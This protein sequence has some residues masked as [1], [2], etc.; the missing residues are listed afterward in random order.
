MWFYISWYY[1]S[2]NTNDIVAE[3][4]SVAVKANEY[5]AN[6]DKSDDAVD[7]SVEAVTK[8]P[9]INIIKK[10]IKCM[11]DNDYNHLDINPE[12]IVINKCLNGLVG[13]EVNLSN[14]GYVIKSAK[15]LRVGIY[16]SDNYMSPNLESISN[17][18]NY[19]NVIYSF[20]VFGVLLYTFICSMKRMRIKHH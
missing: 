12:N 2:K 11:H 3:T 16:H 18:L 19:K 6:A 15:S 10:E 4:K 17:Y 20:S 13:C 14:F 7:D 5:H 8:Y 9:I 1:F